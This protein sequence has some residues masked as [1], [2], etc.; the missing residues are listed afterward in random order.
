MKSEPGFPV[1]YG[2]WTFIEEGT[3][4]AIVRGVEGDYTFLNYA[5]GVEEAKAMVDHWEAHSPA[6]PRTP[7]VPKN[8]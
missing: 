6:F 1:V 2:N 7:Y 5:P 8:S 4:I 3:E